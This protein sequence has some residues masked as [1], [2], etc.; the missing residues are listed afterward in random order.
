MKKNCF[1][2]TLKY[3]ETFSPTQYIQRR[4]RSIRVTSVEGENGSKMHH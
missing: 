3:E 4:D 2:F 1:T